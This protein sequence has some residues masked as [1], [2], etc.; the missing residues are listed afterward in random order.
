MIDI[1]KQVLVGQYE[2]PSGDKKANLAAD[3]DIRKAAAREG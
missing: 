2:L 3:E 1:Y